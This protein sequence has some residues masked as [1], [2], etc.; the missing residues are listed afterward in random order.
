MKSEL[1]S[2]RRF[3]MATA[4]NCYSIVELEKTLIEEISYDIPLWLDNKEKSWL[5]NFIL[6]KPISVMAYFADQDKQIL[7]EDLTSFGSDIN[8]IIKSLQRRGGK[9]PLRSVKYAETL[10][11]GTS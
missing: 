1:E 2:L 5:E 6:S 10:S 8:G 7:R 4:K 11:A 9:L 3:I